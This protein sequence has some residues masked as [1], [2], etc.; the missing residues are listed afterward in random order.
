MTKKPKGKFV[1]DRKSKYFKHW[2]RKLGYSYKF[3]VPIKLKNVRNWFYIKL[4]RVDG[5]KLN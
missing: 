2:N 4:V 5:N 1:M 3:A